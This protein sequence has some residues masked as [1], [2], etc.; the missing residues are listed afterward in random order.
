MALQKTHPRKIVDDLLMLRTNISKQLR[1]CRIVLT[2]STIR[3]GN[4]KAN[5][6]MRNV[7]KHLENLELE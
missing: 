6:T 3:H 4:G 7:N 2:K 1:N 5:L